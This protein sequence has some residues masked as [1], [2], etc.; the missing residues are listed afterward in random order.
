ML[1]H[2]QF[3]YYLKESLIEMCNRQ[4]RGRSK[5]PSPRTCVWSSAR[6]LVCVAFGDAAPTAALASSTKGT[7][8]HAKQMSQGHVRLKKKTDLSFPRLF[9]PLFLRIPVSISSYPTSSY[10]FPSL[11]Y[12]NLFLSV[13]F[14]SITSTIMDP[15]YDP[16]PHVC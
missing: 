9:F 4:A 2:E 12:S 1:L 11:I 14:D 5:G 10:S 13:H 7:R 15:L 8:H 3:S 6:G 16:S